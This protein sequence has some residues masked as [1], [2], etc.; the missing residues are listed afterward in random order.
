MIKP[1]VAFEFPYSNVREVLNCKGLLHENLHYQTNENGYLCYIEDVD[2]D[3][4]A[5]TWGPKP[6]KLAEELVYYGY[7]VGRSRFG[8]PSL[9]K[10]SINEVLNSMPIRDR[11]KVVA[12]E[13][14]PQEKSVWNTSSEGY[15]YFLVK[16]FTEYRED[17][18]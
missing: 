18:E 1:V 17:F 16:T 14:D 9:F 8:A 13:V 2:P 15:H 5:F 3:R 11:E 12:F 7:F 10:P 4:V 6:T